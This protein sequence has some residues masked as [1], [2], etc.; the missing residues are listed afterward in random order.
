MSNDRKNPELQDAVLIEFAAR[1]AKLPALAAAVKKMSADL[2]IR[3][4]TEKVCCAVSE[5]Q[6]TIYL[7]SAGSAH[8]IAEIKR[9]VHARLGEFSNG[10][11]EV[12]RLA[13]VSA[14]AGASSNETPNYHYVVRTDVVS[15]GEEE[16][17]RWYDEEHMPGLAAVSGVISAQRLI[18]LDA[19]P[20]YYACYDL[21]T[22]DVR[23]DPDWLA[24]RATEWSGR[25]R[26]MF[27]DTRRTISRRLLELD[28]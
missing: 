1:D 18:S 20:R 17:E 27:R 6:V 14:F 28:L 7:Q 5:P 3:P 2:G 22:P 4:G 10:D 23:D 24:M 11:F 9:L 19:A 25:V 21:A 26:V 16:L 15:G 13:A 8:E 12:S